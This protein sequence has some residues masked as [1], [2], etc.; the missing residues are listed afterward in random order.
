M[1]ETGSSYCSL[2]PWQVLVDLCGHLEDCNNFRGHLCLVDEETSTVRCDNRVGHCNRAVLKIIASDVEHIGHL[3]CHPWSVRL[4]I[5]H[6]NIT[7]DSCQYTFQHLKTQH[8]FRDLGDTKSGD[9]ASYSPAV[10]RMR[11]EEPIAGK[12]V[13]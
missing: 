7:N 1:E 6:A 3:C 8:S 10:S 9:N 5:A 4:L 11:R 13:S 2:G 12:K